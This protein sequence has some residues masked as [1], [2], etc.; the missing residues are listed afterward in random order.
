MTC[1]DS[2]SELSKFLQEYRV[3]DVLSNVLAPKGLESVDDFAYAFPKLPGLDSVLGNLS[4]RDGIGRPT[5]WGPHEE[6]M[7]DSVQSKHQ[8]QDCL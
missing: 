4:E 5:A 7:R 8:L 2:S 3:H 1:S 6:S